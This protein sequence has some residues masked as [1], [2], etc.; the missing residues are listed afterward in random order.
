MSM[1]AYIIRTI[2]VRMSKVCQVQWLD[3]R[4][5]PPLV[6]AMGLVNISENMKVRVT[7]ISI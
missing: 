7:H 2:Y 3:K 4:K 5:T 1:C 6:K